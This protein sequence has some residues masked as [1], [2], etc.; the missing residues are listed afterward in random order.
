MSNTS[1]QIKEAEQKE[2]AARS[3]LIEIMAEARVREII[4]EFTVIG[5]FDIDIKSVDFDK[6]IIKVGVW[7]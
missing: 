2:A 6:R 7:V 4:G 5:N 3:E 1:N